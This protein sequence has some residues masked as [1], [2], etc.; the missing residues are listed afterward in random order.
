MSAPRTLSLTRSRR[1]VCDLMHFARRVPTVVAERVLHLG[2]AVLARAAL[3]DRPSWYALLTKAHAAVCRDEPRL[4]RCYRGF[5]WPHLYEHAITSATVPIAREVDGEEGLLFLTIPE[6]DTLPLAEIHARISHAKTAP[7]EEVR[8][9]RNQLRIAALPGFLR[10]LAWWLAADVFGRLREKHLG[11]FGVTGVP[12]GGTDT[13]YFLSPLT[14]TV[15][16][17]VLGADGR[18][19]VRILYDHRVLDAG[20]AGRALAGL[21]AV[22]CGVVAEEMRT[23]AGP[24]RAAG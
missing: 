12:S 21:E 1:V 17:G 16:M 18:V 19:P 4:R 8:D 10:R 5:P 13:P 20:L 11:T 23:M 15:T 22:L 24:G 7:L 9:F 3:A 2:P 14:S 6:P